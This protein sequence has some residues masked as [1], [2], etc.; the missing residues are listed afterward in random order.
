MGK[1]SHL[2]FFW[3]AKETELFTLSA[4]F[5]SLESELGLFAPTTTKGDSNLDKTHQC[6]TGIKDV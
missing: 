3:G 5:S 1:N 6:Q 4:F 2:S